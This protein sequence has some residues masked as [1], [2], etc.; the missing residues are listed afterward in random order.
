MKNSIKKIVVAALLVSTTAFASPLDGMRN[1]L[2]GN[3]VTTSNRVDLVELKNKADERNTDIDVAYE[4]YLIAKKRVAIARAA[5]NPITTGHL[6]GISLG[7]TFLWAPIAVEAVT[8][9]PMKI[10]NVSSNKHLAKAALYNTKDAKLA[11]NNELARLYYDVLT[12]EVL[13]KSID[14]EVEVLFYQQDLLEKNAPVARKATIDYNKGQIIALKMERIDIYNL[15]KEEQAALKTLLSLNP[16]VALDFAQNNVVLKKSFLDNLD[17]EKL[18]DF[19]LINSAKFKTN[20]HLHHAAEANV[21]SVQWSILTFSGLNFSWKSRV[22]IAKIDEG[23]A[24]LNKLSTARKVES[25]VLIQKEKLAS[26][27]HLAESY[28]DVSNSSMQLFEDNYNLYQEKQKPIDYSFE[29]SIGAIRDFRN[30]VI[31]H[32]NAWSAMEDF[33]KSTSFNF[34]F[35]NENDN[36]QKQLEKQAF[37]DVSENDFKVVVDNRFESVSLSL[38]SNKLSLVEKV[39]YQFNDSS[40]G[41]LSSGYER[42]KFEATMNSAQGPVIG[43]LS[44]VAVI[45]FKNGHELTVNF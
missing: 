5:F 34:S 9:I 25:E 28:A 6:L 40:Y 33:S 8:S 45:V 16:D 36:A 2:E 3:L 42:S 24:E 10:Y 1:N 29:T 13:L 7:M 26:A 44:G 31:A 20:I 38:K 18:Q 30:K 43:N 14:K 37:Y 22:R 19:A 12:H 11:I 15:L 27:L 4:N 23:V 17:E 35:K 21:K 39:V 41:T 32:Y